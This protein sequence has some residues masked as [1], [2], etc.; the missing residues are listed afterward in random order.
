MRKEDMPLACLLS[1]RMELLWLKKL[2]WT[3][4]SLLGE[5]ELAGMEGQG[6][7]GILGSP[8]LLMIPAIM[9][10]LTV[11]LNTILSQGGMKAL[12]PLDTE[13]ITRTTPPPQVRPS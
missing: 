1:L 13:E 11:I 12:I 4:S 8:D 2:A 10:Q 5:E 6:M 7:E 9:V 3:W